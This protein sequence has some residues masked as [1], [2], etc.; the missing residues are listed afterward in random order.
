MKDTRILIGVFRRLRV[1]LRRK[2]NKERSIR[3]T[4]RTYQ[5]VR[6]GEKVP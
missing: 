2:A 4:H 5:R 1:K 6:E 3:S